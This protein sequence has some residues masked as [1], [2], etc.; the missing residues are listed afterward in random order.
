MQQM[1]NGETEAPDWRPCHH[2]GQHGGWN[3]C[4]SSSVSVEPQTKTE[5]C[6]EESSEPD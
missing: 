4:C 1:L 3:T 2:Q 6:K 5:D